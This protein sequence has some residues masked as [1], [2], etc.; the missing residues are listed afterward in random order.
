MDEHIPTHSNGVVYIVTTTT[1]YTYLDA[2]I[3]SARSVAKHMPSVGIH[4]FTDRAGLA[5]VDTLEKHPFSSLAEVDRPHYRSK[6]E[7]L[8]KTPFERTLYLDSDTRV[9][10]DISEIFALAERFDVALAH[11]HR[12]NARKTTQQ[13]REE[14]PPSF[15]QYN[16]GVMFY[17]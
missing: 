17:R 8:A 15:P 12:R 3:A 4:L 7:Y 13:W 1:T 10:T 16:C 2:A 5:R 9:L 11:A 14:I 6:V